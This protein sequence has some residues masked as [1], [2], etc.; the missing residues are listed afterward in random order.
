[1]P[2]GF[3]L[4]G[5]GAIFLVRYMHARM[6][7]CMRSSAHSYRIDIRRARGRDCRRDVIKRITILRGAAM[8]NAAGNDVALFITRS[9]SGP[10]DD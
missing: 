10:V 9:I 6:Y 3:L 1:M 8:L 4:I 2:F 5:S 7:V